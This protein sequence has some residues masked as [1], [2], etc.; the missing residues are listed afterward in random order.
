MDHR[1]EEQSH[2][3]IRDSNTGLQL[4]SK[5]QI[6]IQCYMLVGYA[7]TIMLLYSIYKHY[8]IIISVDK[9]I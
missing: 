4:V 5:Q 3:H 1:E 8:K 2:N 7:H 6:C 9:I